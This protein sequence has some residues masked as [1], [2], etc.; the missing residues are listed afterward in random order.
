MRLAVTTVLLLCGLAT[1]A[2]SPDTA[3]TG[4]I[5]RLKKTPISQ[6]TMESIRAKPEADTVFNYKSEDAFLPYE[7]WTIRKIIIQTLHFNRTVQDTTRVFKNLLIKA[8][9]KLHTDSRERV[10]RDFLFIKEGQHLN[11]YRVADNER[12]LRDLDFIKDSRIHVVHADSAT[13]TV[14]LLVMPRDVF[15]LGAS[16]EPK[17]IDQ[18][19]LKIQ[20]ANLIGQAMRVQ[21][22]GDY[23]GT[24]APPLSSEWLFQSRNVLGSFIDATIAHTNINT[25]RSLGLENEQ[26]R[27]FRLERPL[28]M[29]YARWA[30]GLELSSNESVNRFLKP[31]T[32]FAQY[33]YRYNDLWAGF[34]FGQ[35]RMPR[36]KLEN[37][38]RKFFSVRLLDQHFTALPTTGFQ[39]AEPNLYVNRKMALAKLTFFR[40]DFYKTKYVFGFGRTED[41]PYGYQLS[42]TGGMERLGLVERPY[43]AVEYTESI[44]DRAGNILSINASLAGY[45]HQGST[46]DVLLRV[47]TSYF[48]K[49]Y[50]MKSWNLRH[51]LE[52]G[53]QRFG[54]RTVKRPLDINGVNGLQG[55]SADSLRG[56]ESFKLRAQLLLFTGW[57]LLGF[58]FTLV[59]Q[60]DLGYLNKV[61]NQSFIHKTLHG[62]SLG[63]RTRNENLI[64]NTIELRGYYFP[65]TVGTADPY[66][67]ELR[68]NLRIKYPTNL[69]RSPTTVFE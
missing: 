58:G 35:S 19:E 7:G 42:F 40:Q 13:Q 15:S 29:P 57:R 48:S 47:A 55:F 24:A 11:P 64:F 46:Q 10:I 3:K 59:P 18:F 8:G 33:K 30:G 43:L 27:Y 34:T 37:R 56:D 49:V 20:E 28:F 52:L 38:N 68:S 51:S 17:D 6:K 54:D 65:K 60:Y 66:R 31:D 45:H 32:L 67:I 2:Q 36:R 25:G 9:E 12:F 21:Y 1:A 4:V 41:I 69:I 61:I 22:L 23:D 62:F 26:A 63:V 53:Y 16:L 50:E 14:D 44:A 39:L 5:D